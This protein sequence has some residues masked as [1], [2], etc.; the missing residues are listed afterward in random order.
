MKNSSSQFFRGLKHPGE[1]AQIYFKIA[2]RP[3]KVIFLRSVLGIRT[4]SE[5]L[6]IMNM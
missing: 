3:M 6:D 2:D 5:C 4:F 1:M